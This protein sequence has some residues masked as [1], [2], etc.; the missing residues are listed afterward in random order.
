M[1][2]APVARPRIS[3]DFIHRIILETVRPENKLAIQHALPQ[4]ACQY[5]T[6]TINHHSY[7]VA[8]HFTMITDQL[9]MNFL[10]YVTVEDRDIAEATHLI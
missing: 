2:R 1:V 4:F 10:A 5:S 9:V 6:V 7:H 8:V 3:I